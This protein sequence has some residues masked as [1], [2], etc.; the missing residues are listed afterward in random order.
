M[1]ARARLRCYA[2]LN[3][4]LPP[5]RRQRE[6]DLDFVAPA[7]LRHL[8]QIAGI[9][10]TEIALALCN[11]DPVDLEHHVHDGDRLSL[12]P[13]FA[14]SGIDAVPPIVLRPPGRPRFL[15]D[16]H[17]GRLAGHLRLLGL[18]TVYQ[19]ALDDRMLAAIAAEEGRILLSRD[20]DLLMHRAV[21]YGA[22]LHTTDAWAGLVYLE[23]RYHLCE[24]AEPFSRCMRC[25]GRL[26][27]VEKAAVIDRVPAAVARLQDA[28]WRCKDCDQVYWR[29]SHWQALQARVTALCG[30]A[31]GRP[32]RT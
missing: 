13:Q 14:T 32:A 31:V 30:R 21:R 12:Y 29:G 26:E 22:Y 9:P 25:N 1:K 3:D 17:L 23:R 18:D 8:A 15:A 24:Y 19:N 27:A 11:G 4:F 5:A 10:H 28:F 2:E 6:F 16:A 20:R 7:P